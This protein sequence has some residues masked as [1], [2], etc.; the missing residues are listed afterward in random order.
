MNQTGLLLFYE[1]S[2]VDPELNVQMWVFHPLQRFGQ[3]LGSWRQRG[4][5]CKETLSV[6]VAALCRTFPFSAKFP[7]FSHFS[8][9]PTL[10]G[11]HTC[12]HAHTWG[13]EE[14]RNE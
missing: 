6:L 3:E 12:Q 5:L 1:V 10:R 13:C 4:C 2:G 14:G 9:P 7:L 8:L 11:S